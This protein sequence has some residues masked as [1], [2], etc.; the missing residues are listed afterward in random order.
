V[1]RCSRRADEREL[2]VVEAGLR[3]EHREIVVDAV[4]IAKGGKV[5][6]PLLRPRVAFGS[7]RPGR[8]GAASREPVRDLA[9]RRLDRLLVLRDADVLL[10]PS[11]RR[12][13]PPAAPAIEDRDVSEV[14]LD[15]PERAARVPNNPGEGALPVRRRARQ[16]EW[17]GKKCRARG[18][19]FAFSDSRR[20]SAW[21]MSGRARQQVGR[22]AF[23]ELSA[24]ICLTSSA[25]PAAGQRATAVR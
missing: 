3:R 2:R 10:D 8:E 17:V 23:P 16:A 6:R 13:P 18:A 24:R 20:A 12:A 14:R 25:P 11:R 5:E 4:S 1:R 9:E 15:R 7:L 22:Q 21:R 19:M